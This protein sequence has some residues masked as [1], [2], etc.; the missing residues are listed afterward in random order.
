[1]RSA[2][3]KI[4]TLWV[5]GLALAAFCLGWV[6]RAESEYQLEQGARQSAL[7]WANFASRTVPDLE[8]AFSGRGITDESPS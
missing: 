8:L 2:D 6:L 5:I 1:M 3:W 7:R 4:F